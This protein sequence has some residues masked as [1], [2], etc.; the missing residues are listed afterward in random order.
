MTK[1]VREHMHR[2]S[3]LHT[4]QKQLVAGWRA[5]RV[6]PSSYADVNGAL[7]TT[8]ASNLILGH[9]PAGSVLSAQGPLF[10]V[11]FALSGLGLMRTLS[12]DR[13]IFLVLIFLPTRLIEGVNR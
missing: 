12:L 11:A 4:D 5:G 13:T 2:E 8:I 9:L 10:G 3:R 7:S 6:G 1:I